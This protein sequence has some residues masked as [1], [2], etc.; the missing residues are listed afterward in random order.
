MPNKRGF[1]SLYQQKKKG[2]DGNLVTLPTW[3]IKYSKGGQ[4]FRESSGSY[5]RREERIRIHNLT[6]EAVQDYADNNRGSKAHVERRLKLHIIP[7][8]GDIRA[9]DFGPPT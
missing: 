3:W 8:L 1:G 4:V 6:A 9:A 2:P 5:D 7:E